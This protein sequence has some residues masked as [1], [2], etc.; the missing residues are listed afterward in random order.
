MIMI[1]ILVESVIAT[2]HYLTLP[3]KAN[4]PTLFEPLVCND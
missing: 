1:L 4:R 2:S 3:V